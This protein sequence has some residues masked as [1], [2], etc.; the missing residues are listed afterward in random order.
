MFKTTLPY[1][2]RIYRKQTYMNTLMGTFTQ[3]N[4]ILHEYHAAQILHGYRV[5]IPRGH[6]AFNGKEAYT[7]A[8]KFGS[9]YSKKFVVKAQVQVAGRTK[10]YFKENGMKGGIHVCD[11]IE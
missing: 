1:L 9:E 2:N 8:R 11:N 4:M 10:G 6:V 3:R 5:P 7:I